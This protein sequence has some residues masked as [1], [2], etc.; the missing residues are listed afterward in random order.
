MDQADKEREERLAAL[1]ER[2]R[3]LGAAQVERVKAHA[4]HE[5]IMAG[6]A[7]I[8]AIVAEQLRLK[9]DRKDA[10]ENDYRQ[11]AEDINR[12]L[13]TVWKDDPAL[14]HD[15]ACEHAALEESAHQLGI[16]LTPAQELTHDLG[17]EIEW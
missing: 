10:L 14:T 8:D 12:D 5:E 11:L 6:N 16:E 4:P 1:K 7:D 3:V 15:L 2:G 17:I 13:H 9:H